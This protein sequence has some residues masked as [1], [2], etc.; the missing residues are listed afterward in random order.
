MPRSDGRRLDDPAFF[1]AG[2]FV[3]NFLLQRLSALPGLSISLATPVTLAWMTYGL[4]RGILVIEPRRAQLFGWAVVASALATFF[5]LSLVSASSLSVGSWAFWLLIWIGVVVRFRDTS[6]A[7]TRRVAAALARVG[8]WI[9]ALSIFFLGIQFA[10]VPYRDYLASVVPAPFLVDGFVISYPIAYGNPV[11]KSNA[12]LALEPSFLS[13]MLGICAMCSLWAGLSLWRLLLL[14]IGILSTFA[15]SG[16]AVLLVGVVIML[17]TGQ[18]AALRK[19]LAVG[20]G[21]LV[22]SA[23]TPIGAYVFARADE[24]SRSDSSSSLRAI[25]PY[26]VLVP[27]WLADPAGILFGYGAGSARQTIDDL[28]QPGLVV[29][30]VAKMIFEYGLIAGV[31]LVA[32]IVVAHTRS[33]YPA[34]GISVLFS[35]LV[36]Q[37]AS[38]PLVNCGL[39]CVTWCSPAVRAWARRDWTARD[40]AAQPD[41]DG[42]VEAAPRPGLARRI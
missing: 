4:A 31:I 37:P 15:G 39:A 17:F 7:T 19:H 24:V 8:G 28:G 14:I 5:H 3:A 11:Y 9:S 13:F 16:L 1:A 35:F 41:D 2:F 23:F 40:W 29:P 33:P 38:Q 21:L 10:G 20:A 30:N 26:A 22:A 42:G 12:W 34:L 18:A 6:P 27:R 25:E 32:V 36:L